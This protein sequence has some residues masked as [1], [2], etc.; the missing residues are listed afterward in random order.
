MN[1]IT[2]RS[3]MKPA[4]KME[5]YLSDEEIERFR[6]LRTNHR[7]E[8]VQILYRGCH[9]TIDT[10][11]HSQSRQLIGSGSFEDSTQSLRAGQFI[12]VAQI[13]RN[14]IRQELTDGKEGAFLAYLTWDMLILVEAQ[15]RPGVYVRV[16]PGETVQRDWFDD[17]QETELVL[18]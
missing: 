16:G 6:G 12:F 10:E 7:P 14:V 5:A 2:I 4:L 15:G 11:Q 18:I 8:I 13:S 3:R 17:V 1:T 9:V